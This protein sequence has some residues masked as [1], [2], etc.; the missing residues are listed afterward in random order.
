[1]A[2][3]LIPSARLAKWYLNLKPMRPSEYLTQPQPLQRAQMEYESERGDDAFHTIF[4]LELRGKDVLDLGCGYGGRTVYFKEM[5]ARSIAGIEPVEACISEALAFAQSRNVEIRALVAAAESLPLPNESFDA[6][7]SYDVFEH[8]ENLSATLRECYRV[9]RPG[10]VVYAVFPPFYHPTGGS[11][12]HGYVSTSPGPQLLFSCRAL[13]NA[14]RQM[15]AEGAIS[16][17]PVF[18]PNDCL[19][20]QNGATVRSFLS[21]LKNVPFREKNVRLDPMSSRRFPW[22]GTVAA[23]GSRLPL[24]REIFTNRIVCKLVK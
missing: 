16:Y 12:L 1:M 5:G 23:A 4:N 3:L 2:N 10:G 24:L 22:L 7:T 15:L 21:L 18:R 20:Q 14:L 8:V 13:R 9:L 17:T 11:H 6:I 19:P